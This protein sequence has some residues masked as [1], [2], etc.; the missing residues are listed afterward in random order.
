MGRGEREMGGERE[1]ERATRERDER[2]KK[3]TKK[4]KGNIKQENHH[5]IQK[6]GKGS[7]WQRLSPCP[8]CAPRRGGR[9]GA[10][11]GIRVK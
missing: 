6:K 10:V 7:A 2:N 1:K 9:G 4:T 3:E 8:P 11:G 5:A